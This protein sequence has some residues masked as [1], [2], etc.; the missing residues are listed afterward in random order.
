MKVVSVDNF[1]R[2]SVAD[3]LIK[4]N[5]SKE[6]GERIVKEQN[7]KMN[8]NSSDCYVLKEDNYRLWRGM[9]DLV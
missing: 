3:E 6:E 9:E 2:E 4:E 1:N 7:D 5:V 8:P